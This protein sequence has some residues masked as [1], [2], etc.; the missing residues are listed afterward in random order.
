MMWYKSKISLSAILAC[1][2]IVS[3]ASSAHAIT[4]VGG[5]DFEDN[6]FADSTV[7]DNPALWATDDVTTLLENALVGS[8]AS[9]AAFAIDNSDAA[10]PAFVDILFTDNT[11]TNIAGP[12]LAVFDLGSEDTFAA[13]IGATT[14]LYTSVGVA[15]PFPLN[16]ALIDLSDFGIAEGDSISTLTLLSNPVENPAGSSATDFTVIAGITVIDTGDNGDNGDNGNNGNNNAVPEPLT[17]SLGAM[18]IA[19]LGFGTRRRRIA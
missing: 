15:N 4:T 17:A 19:A 9:D 12:D 8:L 1:A 10:D 18:A 13:Q 2:L 6:A 5:L 11:I 7:F 3:G 16:V 14:N